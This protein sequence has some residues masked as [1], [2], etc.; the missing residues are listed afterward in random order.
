MWSA[1]V[2]YTPLLLLLSVWCTQ[3]LGDSEMTGTQGPQTHLQQA[4]SSREGPIVSSGAAAAPLVARRPSRGGLYCRLQY[5]TDSS[6]R[7]PM[8]GTIRYIFF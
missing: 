6:S 4:P 5:S 3:I 7:S 8:I 2:Y 1:V